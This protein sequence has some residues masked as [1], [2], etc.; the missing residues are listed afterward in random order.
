MGRESWA[1]RS[2]YIGDELRV[3]DCCSSN[4]SI[5]FTLNLLLLF[6]VSMLED[7][8]RGG[9]QFASSCSAAGASVRKREARPSLGLLGREGCPII[10]KQRLPQGV[11]SVLDGLRIHWSVNPCRVA[12]GAPLEKHFYTQNLK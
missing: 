4:R 1:L 12:C 9:V 7:V 5:A 3:W 8:E 10:L 2:H 6:Q 11:W